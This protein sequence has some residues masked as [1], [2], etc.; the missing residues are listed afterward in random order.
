MLAYSNHR[1]LRDDCQ[2][3]CSTSHVSTVRLKTVRRV[4]L[5]GPGCD[6]FSCTFDETVGRYT[7]GSKVVVRIHSADNKITFLF[8]DH[9]G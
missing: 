6:H 7:D 1:L 9:K 2:L 4:L 5:H 3:Y 8:T